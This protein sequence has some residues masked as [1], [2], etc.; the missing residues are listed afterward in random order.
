[1][2]IYTV[3]G[4]THMKIKFQIHRCPDWFE[5][6]VRAEWWD[7]LELLRHREQEQYKDPN[8][9]LELI[10]RAVEFY[11]EKG[12]TAWHEEDAKGYYIWLDIDLDKPE[13]TLRMLK[14]L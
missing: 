1:M 6:F 13:W 5:N 3:K 9:Q 4:Y 12:L 7:E 11:T 8:G 2:H 10:A 14:Y